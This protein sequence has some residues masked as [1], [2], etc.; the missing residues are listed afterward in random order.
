MGCIKLTRLEWYLSF[1]VVS[2]YIA[3]DCIHAKVFVATLLTLV[4]G[5]GIIFKVTFVSVLL[6]SSSINQLPFQYGGQQEEGQ[7]G[8]EVGTVAGRAE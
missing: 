4:M 5:M 2:P 1:F 6:L 3:W 7:G 8:G